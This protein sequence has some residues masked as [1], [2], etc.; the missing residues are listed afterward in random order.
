MDIGSENAGQR[1]DHRLVGV[2]QPDL[3]VVDEQRHERDLHGH[4][5]AEQEQGAHDAAEPEPEH[6]QGV[7]G[8][9]PER[10]R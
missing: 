7:G 4:D 1:D 3:R 8:H 5:D 10:P 9:H 6:L 2:E